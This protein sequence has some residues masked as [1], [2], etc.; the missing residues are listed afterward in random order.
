MSAQEDP[1]NGHGIPGS[2]SDTG[3]FTFQRDKPMAQS[4]EHK[5]ELTREQGKALLALARRTLEG[6]FRTA[7]KATFNPELPD[8]A[9]QSRCG[10]F[11]TLKMKN[12]LRG[13]IGSLSS[14]SSIVEGIREN[15][16]NAALHD[17]RFPPLS[18]AELRD[19]LIE[20][21]VLTK[22]VL[23]S[24]SDANDL[25]LKLRPTIDGV[26]LRKGHASATFLPQVW[27]QLPRPEAFL[28]H[29]CQKAGLDADRWRQGDLTVEVY[30]VQHFDEKK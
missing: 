26:I 12:Q 27:E 25:I 20:V 5:M 22:P 15:V 1:Y 23:L 29:L 28:S 3:P 13:C 11:V 14:S 8:E 10:T 18:E 9:L 21:S 7:G 2:P 4:A 17:P 19:V 6:H 30:Q 16:L 24:Y